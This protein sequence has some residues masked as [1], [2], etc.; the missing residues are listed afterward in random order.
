M[1][2]EEDSDDDEDLQDLSDDSISSLEDL[3]SNSD[4][5]LNVKDRQMSF[6]KDL[7]KTIND[8]QPETE[9]TFKGGRPDKVITGKPEMGITFVEDDEREVTFSKHNPKM[10]ATFVENEMDVTNGNNKSI[11]EVTYIGDDDREIS[12]KKHKPDMDVSFNKNKPNLE[13]TFIEDN[14]REATFNKTTSDMEVTFIDADDAKEVSLKKD[15]GYFS[16]FGATRVQSEEK[17]NEEDFDQLDRLSD[18]LEGKGQSSKVTMGQCSKVIGQRPRVTMGQ[19]SKV[20]GQSS[21]VITAHQ[22]QTPNAASGRISVRR[23]L[24]DDFEIESLN[25]STVE[26]VSKVNTITNQ[27]PKDKIKSER[28]NTNGKRTKRFALSKPPVPSIEQSYNTL[29]TAKAAEPV[30]ATGKPVPFKEMVQL[31]IVELAEEN[32]SD[33][34]TILQFVKR[35]FK[36]T[37]NIDRKIIDSLRHSVNKKQLTL[38][39]KGPLGKYKLA[40]NLETVNST[41]K[42][43]KIFQVLKIVEVSRPYLTR[44][45][46]NQ[47][48]IR[49]KGEHSILP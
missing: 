2:V 19:S 12:F 22:L 37:S 23:N 15:T 46:R 17:V 7:D 5:K 48:K 32:G 16:F 45:S 18:P 30:A 34:N 39:G 20:I 26:H 41:K 38:T 11:M 24:I 44:S 31:A 47:G 14:H 8:D 1:E 27:I 13:V 43:R 25:E 6:V 3:E 33:R 4:F 9:V 40:E 42:T 29:T 21:K 36:P 10:G 35:K 49:V 28:N